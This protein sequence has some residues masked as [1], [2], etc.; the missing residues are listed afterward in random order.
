MVASASAPLQGLE[1]GGGTRP[2]SPSCSP[3]PVR[4]RRQGHTRLGEAA[5]LLGDVYT[6]L[7]IRPHDGRGVPLALRSSDA[8]GV[9]VSTLSISSS[10][11]ST[12]A[13]PTYVVTVPR[14]RARPR[15]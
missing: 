11:V 12:A 10:L 8:D 3:A 13:M 1:G 9:R 15:R 4:R 2:G 5:S 6:P 7:T 14:H